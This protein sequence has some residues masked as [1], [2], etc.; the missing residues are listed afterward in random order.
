MKSVLFIA[1]AFAHTQLFRVGQQT[2]CIRPTAA[3]P[4][5]RNFPIKD[6]TSQDMVCGQAPTRLSSE[7]CQV[8]AGSSLDLI[9]GHNSP[10]D[11]VVDPSHSGPCNVYLVPSARTQA[12]PPSGWF[13]IFEGIWDPVNKWCV[14]KLIQ[15]RG[16]LSVPIPRD[17]QSGDYILRAEINALQESDVAFTRNPARG[18]QFYIFCADITVRGGGSRV[19]PQSETVS[20]P[21]YLND[22]SPGVV[23]NMF[24]QGVPKSEAGRNYPTLGPRVVSLVQGGVVTSTVNSI[25]TV[26]PPAPQPPAPQQPAPQQPQQ[27]APQPQVPNQPAPQ[28]NQ[29]APQS[30][31]GRLPPCQGPLNGSLCTT[32]GSGAFGSKESIVALCNSCASQ[33]SQKGQNPRDKLRDCLAKVEGGD[34]NPVMP[35]N[36]FG[37]DVCSADVTAPSAPSAPAAPSSPNSQPVTTLPPC[38]GPLN[39]SLCTTSGSGAFG[40]K[41]SIVALCNSCASQ[42][43]QKGQNP[44]DKL[45]DCLAKVEGGDRNPVMPLNTFGRDVCSQ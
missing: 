27:P 36:T 12:P 10:Q 4:E 35:L 24:N 34:R 28:P 9:W 1:T 38:Q 25:P 23:F 17:L 29:P 8:E 15:D 45:R 18:S 7:S 11:D 26:L 20:I 42:A 14:D 32:S 13:K 37:R 6:I 33:A 43:S 16:V 40:S 39:G 5:T 19:A 44:R 41:E 21:G 31:A 2:G 30:P 3:G 22:Q